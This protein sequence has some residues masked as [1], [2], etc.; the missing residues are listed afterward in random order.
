MKLN[1]STTPDRLS[2]SISTAAGRLRLDQLNLPL[3]AQTITPFAHTRKAFTN[4]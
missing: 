2:A 3:M 1:R 4:A